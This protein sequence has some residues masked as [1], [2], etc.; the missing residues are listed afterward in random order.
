MTR[1]GVVYAVAIG[2]F[3][4]VFYPLRSWLDSDLLFFVV[5]IVYAASARFVAEWAQRRYLNAQVQKRP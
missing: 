2:L 4:L 3:G 5:A 1:A